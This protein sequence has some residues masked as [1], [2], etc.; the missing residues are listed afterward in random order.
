MEHIPS[1]ISMDTSGE[2][3]RDLLKIYCDKT[4]IT[5]VLDKGENTD[6]RVLKISL[7][8]VKTSA[9][10]NIKDANYISF[11]TY[12]GTLGYNKKVFSTVV[13]MDSGAFDLAAPPVME[14]NPGEL[15]RPCKEELP[16]V[17]LDIKMYNGTV[18]ILRYSEG[19]LSGGEKTYNVITRS[20]PT[21]VTELPNVAGSQVFMDGWYSF[22][23]IIFRN[24]LPGAEVMKGDIYNMKGVIFKASV[25]GKAYLEKDSVYVLDSNETR[26]NQ[27]STSNYIDIL[28]SLANSTGVE[29]NARSL[30]IHSQLLVTDQLR[31]AITE[32]VV[33]ASFSVDVDY[34]EFQTW[35]KLTLKRT[36]AYVMFENEL[37]EKAQVILE[38]ARA[39]CVEQKY[40]S[41]PHNY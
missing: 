27:E 39:L 22:T 5:P 40:N 20:H 37:F 12:N 15:V 24:M 2:L 29:A 25:S 14:Y 33:K 21:I 9:I 8:N 28:H 31:D 13:K 26:H 41:L 23:C 16:Q 11:L 32:E 17:V 30:F 38:S 6:K 1:V 35:Q 10:P 7:G 36:S 4:A 18:D 34:V 3:G 19:T